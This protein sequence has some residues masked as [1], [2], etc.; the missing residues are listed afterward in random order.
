MADEP[1]PALTPIINSGDAPV[2]FFDAAPTMAAFNGV[3]AISLTA[4]IY[5]PTG[6]GTP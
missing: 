6:E 4:M 1:K 3:V 5:T 2:I